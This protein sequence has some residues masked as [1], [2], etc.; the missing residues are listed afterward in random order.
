MDETEKPMDIL[1]AASTVA[2]AAAAVEDDDEEMVV[3]EAH[4]ELDGVD[5]VVDVVDTVELKRMYTVFCNSPTLELHVLAQDSIEPNESWHHSCS[6]PV[7]PVDLHEHA[8]AEIHAA[9]A[10]GL[11]V[12]SLAHTVVVAVDMVD[13]MDRAMPAVAAVDHDLHRAAGGDM[14]SFEMDNSSSSTSGICFNS[15]LIVKPEAEGHQES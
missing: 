8:V 4:I 6:M 12:K 13:N 3:V 10:I 7:V 9:E 15:V 5:D 1:L 2:V 14:T 11:V